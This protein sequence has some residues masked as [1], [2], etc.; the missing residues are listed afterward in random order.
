VTPGVPDPSAIPGEVANRLLEREAWARQR[1]AAHAGRS[2]ALAIGP[3]ATKFVIDASG[4]FDSSLA[5]SSPPDLTLRLSPFDVP[6]FLADP[7]RWDRFVAA[8]GDGALAATLKELAPT[9]PWFVERVFATALGPIVGQRVADAGRRLL[10]FPEYAAERVG[11]SVASY[12]HEQS[13]LLAT[14]DEGLAFADAVQ[15]AAARTD[16]LAARIDALAARLS[17]RAAL[18]AVPKDG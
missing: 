12:A 7:S 9:L 3:V 10:A 13:G 5:G 8:E 6:A 15:S 18:R 1:L 2:F 17:E 16:A 14:A 4:Q 11:A